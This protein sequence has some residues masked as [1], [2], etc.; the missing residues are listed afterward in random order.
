MA[1]S[2]THDRKMTIVLGGGGARG[3]LQ[4]GALRALW[5]SG[6]QPELLVGTSAGAINAAFLGTHGFSDRALAQ[7]EEAW[8]QA[9]E[10]DLLPSN[11]VGMALRSVLRRS[12]S[13]PASRIREFLIASGVTEQLRFCELPGPRTVLVSSDLNTGK[14]VL[15]GLR[16]DDGVLEALL[17]STALPPWV[18]PVKRQGHYLMDGAVVSALPIEPA[19]NC[20][21]KDIVALDLTDPRDTFGQ[22]NGLGVFLNSITYA[23]EERQVAL[24]LQAA[25]SRGVPVYHLRLNSSEPVPVWD[26][27]RARDLIA[28]GYEIT[29]RALEHAQRAPESDMPIR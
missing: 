12:D 18:L 27:R 13:S 25:H 26:F 22:A 11:Y 15:H 19:I 5:E 1:D 7:L 4:A 6:C 3:A 28:E 9:S 2:F 10:L 20:G 29:R 23:I 16:G 21:A 17:V 8:Y 24:E 14:P